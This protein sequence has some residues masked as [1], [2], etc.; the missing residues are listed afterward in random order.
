MAINMKREYHGID[1]LEYT[2]K[3]ASQTLVDLMADRF[4]CVRYRVVGE[5]KVGFRALPAP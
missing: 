2:A 1:R 5:T 3:H 4:P